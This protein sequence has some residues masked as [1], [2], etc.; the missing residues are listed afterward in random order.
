MSSHI[1]WKVTALGTG[2]LR[3]I[4]VIVRKSIEYV[5]MGRGRRTFIASSTDACAGQISTVLLVCF[6]QPCQQ[7]ASSSSSYPACSQQVS[8]N[9]RNSVTWWGWYT[10]THC[11]VCHLYAIIIASVLIFNSGLYLWIEHKISRM[12][13][14]QSCD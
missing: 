13:L 14:I 3:K 10:A 7:S 1:L 4:Q 11:D 9:C 6:V 12:C 5:L 2:R 8:Y